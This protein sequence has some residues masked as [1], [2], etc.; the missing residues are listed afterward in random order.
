MPAPS[1]VSGSA[2][3]APRCSRLRSAVRPCS[4]RS[5][6]LRPATS[7][8][9]ATPH[10]SCSWAGSYRPC[11]GGSIGGLPSGGWIVRVPATRDVAGPAADDEHVTRRALVTR[12]AQRVQIWPIRT[13]AFAPGGA[14]L[15][16]VAVPPSGRRTVTHVGARRQALAGAVV[17]A[18][19]P[20]VAALVLLP[21][22]TVWLVVVAILLV[23]EVALV[24]RLLVTDKRVRQGEEQLTL[25]LW[26]GH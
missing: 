13:M 20:V 24:L 14:T 1:P 17:L 10:A 15:A 12:L 3:E 11:A 23:S 18:H 22:T 7:T 2:P 25:A 5:W 26:E 8:T 21:V 16:D 4:T 19:L 6:L 9:K